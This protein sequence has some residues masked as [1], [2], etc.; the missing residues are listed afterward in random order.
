MKSERWSRKRACSWSARAW[1]STGRSRGSWIESAAVITSTSRRQP[2]R[3]ASR[4]IRPSRGSI[5]SRAA[6]G[7]PW[8]AAAVPASRGARAPSSSSSWTPGADVRAVRR[9]D[10]RE[11]RD[12][13][14]PERGHLQDHAGQVGAQDLRLGELAG[15]PRSP[16]R[17]RAG[18]RCRPRPGRSGRSAGC[19]EAW[20]I[21]SIGS[22]CTL[23]RAEY[24]LIRAS[25]VSIDG[26]DARDGQR[27]LGDVGGQHDAAAACAARRPG[28]ARPRR[29][30]RRAGRRRSRRGPSDGACSASAVSRISRSPGRKTRMSP[31]SRGSSSS[32]A[33]TIASV[34]SRTTGSP[35][36]S[37]SRTLDQRPVAHLDRVGAARR[38]R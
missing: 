16:P 18:S 35:S 32:T 7:R 24:R 3:S 14:E 31:A 30:G 33:A 26:G 13:A 12:L 20:L 36:S 6:G 2:S 23:V 21:G 34:W 1:C 38:P 37:S 25:P 9:L 27:G 19:A 29:A 10:E 4:I 5:G 22:R 15:G 8:S 17:S 28:A 11:P